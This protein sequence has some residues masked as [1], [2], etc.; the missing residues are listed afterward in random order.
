MAKLSTFREKLDAM[1]AE[2]IAEAKK[3]LQKPRN[4]RGRTTNRVATGKLRDSLTFGYWKRGDMIVQWYGPQE[5]SIREYADVIEKGRRKGA[6]PPPIEP[7]MRWMR[8]RKIKVRD[9]KGRFTEKN[10]ANMRFA[11]RKISKAISRNGIK[12]INYMSQAFD[13]VFKKHK[14]QLGLAMQIDFLN[15]FRLMSDKY[16][17]K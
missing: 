4:I 15:E 17:N 14:K 2:V 3:N 6:T 10:D 11:A 1:G 12:G 16:L 5:K 8:V 9:S 7:I 13:K